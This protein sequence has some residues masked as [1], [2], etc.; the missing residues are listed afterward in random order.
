MLMLLLDT[1]LVF[2]LLRVVVILLLDISLVKVEQH[3]LRIV[4]VKR[5]LLLDIKLL[6]VLQLPLIT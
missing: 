5:I 4:Q 1:K 2:M 3:L 6:L